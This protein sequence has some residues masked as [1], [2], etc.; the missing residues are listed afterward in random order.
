M[1]DILR[2]EDRYYILS[3][4]SLADDRVRVLKHGETFAV[5]DRR[6]NAEP[7][8]TSVQGVYPEET[9]Y[10]SLWVLRLQNLRPLLLSSWIK[11]DNASLTVDVTNPDLYANGQMVVPRGTLHIARS[12]FLWEGTH[13]A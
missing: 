8:G 7:L 9:R 1:D 3:T 6:G 12:K 4:S 2:V 13:Y 10:L 11:D 5:F